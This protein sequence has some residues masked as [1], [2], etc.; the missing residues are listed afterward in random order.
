MLK[1]IIL[2]DDY[3]PDSTR[4]HAKMLHELALEFSNRGHKVVVLTPG[5]YKQ[6]K[7]REIDFVNN[8]EVWRF[9]SK[10][11]RQVSKIKRAINESMLSFR[12]YLAVRKYIDNEKFDICVNY[13]PTIFFGP[14][15]W[16]F[17]CNKIYNYLILRD[18][19]PQ[20][21]IDQ[22]LIKE[23][24]LISN[25]FRLF[26][27]INYS[28]ADNIAV[29]SPANLG[30]FR[31]SNPEKYNLTV[32][33][34]WT[35]AN[36]T[37]LDL[38]TSKDSLSLDDKVVL[39]YGGNIGHAQDMLNIMRLARNLKQCKEA[40]ILLVGQGDEYKLVEQKIA[41][42]KLDNVTLLPSVTQEQYVKIVASMDIGLFSLSS[43]HSAHNI[44][45]KLLSYMNESLPILGS[46]NKNNDIIDIINSSN[47]GL[48]TINGHDREFFN[49]AMKLINDAN[50][51]KDMGTN[52]HNLINSKF[53][54]E[55]AASKII[56]TFQNSNIS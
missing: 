14:L 13:S 25:Y 41:E 19:F 36:P 9:K 39:F 17:K 5:K 40:H 30:L 55:T 50:L 6:N 35:R 27:K 33:Y 3:L 54:V 44:P 24:S 56:S 18:F 21:A 7:L 4:V 42:W 16:F 31:Q 1:I 43:K 10:P 45:G 12:A 51:R 34:N 23:D 38:A 28:A 22:G 11:T 52:S 46:V 49:N 20:W 8:I 26:E 37:P 48:I 2:S 29:Q 15:A 47:S 53:S 32:L